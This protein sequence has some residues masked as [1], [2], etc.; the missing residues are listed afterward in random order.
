[1]HSLRHWDCWLWPMLQLTKAWTTVAAIQTVNHAVGLNNGGVGNA[2]ITKFN[3]T[4]SALVYSTYLGGSSNDVALAVAVDARGNTCVTGFTQSNDFPLSHA[5]QAQ[6][7]AARGGG[8][9]FVTKFNAAGNALK[10]STY[11]G[12]TNS[13]EAN[14]IAVDLD[15]NAYVA[16]LPH[17]RKTFQSLTPYSTSTIAPSMVPAMPFCSV[18][19]AVGGA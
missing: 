13:D 19:N 2:F 15:G 1:M 9:A 5:W 12:G 6:Y 4:G 8:N 7:K 17:T 18:F 16:G 3:A 14:A 11:L 10:Y